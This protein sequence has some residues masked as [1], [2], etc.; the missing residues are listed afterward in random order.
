MLPLLRFAEDN[1]EHSLHEAT[2]FLAEKFS[3]T[4][5]ELQELLPSGKQTIFINRVG[6]A[7][8]YLSKAELLNSTKRGFF[9][10]S[11]R[12]LS[13]LS[14]NLSRIDNKTLRQ[15]SEFNEFQNRKNE[16]IIR[17]VIENLEETHSTPEESLETAYHPIRHSLASD[18]LA[19]VKSC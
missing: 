12:G 4:E 3:V 1:K 19:P 14:Q 9:Q 10:I 7:R 18:I 11:K 5:N 6:W 17:T 2:T 15:F 13:I 16:K 8:T